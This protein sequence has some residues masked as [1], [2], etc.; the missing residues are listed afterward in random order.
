MIRDHRPNSFLVSCLLEAGPD[1]PANRVFLTFRPL[2][3]MIDNLP[4]G[5]PVEMFYARVVE[6]VDTRD[7]KSL[8][9]MSCAGS[10][11]APGTIENKG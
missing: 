7:L 6:L 9:S 8:G 3:I 5:F 4:D 1:F 11:P 10:I 2:E